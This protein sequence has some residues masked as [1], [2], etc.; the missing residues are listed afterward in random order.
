MEEYAKIA[1]GKEQKNRRR[2]LR[3][4][5]EK[6]ALEM[7]NRTATAVMRQCS[8]CNGNLDDIANYGFGPDIMS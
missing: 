6:V 4:Q 7:N 5:L 2:T 1:D 3:N 8:T